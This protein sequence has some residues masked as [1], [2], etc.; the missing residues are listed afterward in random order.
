MLSHCAQPAIQLVCLS[1][2]LH[3]YALYLVTDCAAWDVHQAD[4]AHRDNPNILMYLLSWASMTTL[5]CLQESLSHTITIQALEAQL[6][7]MDAM[8][9]KPVSPGRLQIAAA[10]ADALSQA[11][12]CPKVADEFFGVNG[13]QNL[14]VS[15]LLPAFEPTTLKLMHC[16]RMMC[17]HCSD[18]K[19][20]AREAVRSHGGLLTLCMLI[21]EVASS[22]RETSDRV[23]IAAMRTLAAATEDCRQNCEFAT[24]GAILSCATRSCCL[25]SASFPALSVTSDCL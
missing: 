17:M 22:V 6:P 21:N 16:T 18:G 3:C 7:R 25:N 11:L 15:L 2:M 4:P 20:K 8:H 24:A 1:I 12:T 14:I 23:L 13:A 5:A 19:V 9:P 10:A